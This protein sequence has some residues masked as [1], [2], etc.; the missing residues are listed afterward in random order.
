MVGGCWGRRGEWCC[1]CIFW[2]GQRCEWGVGLGGLFFYGKQRFLNGSGVGGK[3]VGGC[4][5][6]DCVCSPCVFEVWY[7]GWAKMVGWGWRTR[8]M[9]LKGYVLGELCLGSGGVGGC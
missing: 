6:N 7:W 3:G 8:G 1:E 2:V 5:I 9:V 4:W